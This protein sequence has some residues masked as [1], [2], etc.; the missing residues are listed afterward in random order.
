MRGRPSKLDQ[1]ASE[2][3]ASLARRDNWR[4]ADAAL[5]RRRGDRVKW[6]ALGSG[7]NG[8]A[9]DFSMAAHANS[10]KL[11]KPGCL[12][13]S[14]FTAYQRSAH[15]AFDSPNATVLA[16]AVGVLRSGAL[17]AAIEEVR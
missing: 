4:P 2:G 9:G 8:P 16:C 15:N 6:A 7:S 11:V 5:Y 14:C 3:W 12:S 1:H 17:I 13:H 10:Q